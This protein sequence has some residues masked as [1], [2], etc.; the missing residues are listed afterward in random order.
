MTIQE[1]HDNSHYRSLIIELQ[2]AKRE[3][4]IHDIVLLDHDLKITMNWLTPDAKVSE[5]AEHISSK[6]RIFAEP[7]LSSKT[8]M[9]YD[10]YSLDPKV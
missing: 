8:I 6:Y 7:K 5:V 1:N 2:K 9:I 10:V 3:G 4:F